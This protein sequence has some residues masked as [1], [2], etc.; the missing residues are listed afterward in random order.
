MSRVLR[1]GV[2]GAGV[3]GGYHA[4]KYAGL[5]S[6]EIS[7]LFDPDLARAKILANE[8]SIEAFS[9][10]EDLIAQVD[11]LTVA[12]PATAHAQVALAA[13]A[14]GV[15]VYV[16]KP[17]ATTRADAQA[18]VD[19]A[20]AGGLV[21]SCGHQERMVFRAMGLLDAPEAPK[22]LKAVRRGPFSAR[23]NDVSCV[24]DLM[25]HDLDL[26]LCLT[27][28][29]PMTVRAQGQALMGP[30]FDE[31]RTQIGFDDGLT[32]ELEASRIAERRERTMEVVY[33]S[34]EVRIDFLERTFSNTTNFPLNP[35]FADTPA[36]RDP[37]GTNVAGFLAAVRGEA[38]GPLVTGEEAARALDLAL[39]VEDAAS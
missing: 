8:L 39:T 3:F 35:D 22:R 5:E 7:G 26:A 31:V 36:G 38:P 16:E 12:A 19:A 20:A 29:M 4:R 2:V 14:R 9:N 28:S 11:V 17:L 15:H 6:I 18:L 25:I 10:L 23:A 37:L 34:G 13:L 27:R 33:P 24:L 30:H 1:A 21:L 32:V